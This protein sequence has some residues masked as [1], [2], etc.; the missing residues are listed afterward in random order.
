M[1]SSIPWDITLFSPLKVN[2]LFEGT[3]LHLQLCLPPVPCWFLARLILRTRRWRRHGP[4]KRQLPCNGL[5]KYVAQKVELT[6]AP[7]MIMCLYWS[8][9]DIRLKPVSEFF[10]TAGGGGRKRVSSS[11]VQ[12]V[13]IR[14]NS[15]IKSTLAIV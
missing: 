7:E 4:A 8:L 14:R 9:F 12:Y 15:D 5:H 13:I 1:K 10:D 3:C 11:S 6:L 2:R